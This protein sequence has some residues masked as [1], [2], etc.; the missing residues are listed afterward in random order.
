MFL[1]L[2]HQ[3]LEVF[4]ISRKLVKECY[5]ITREFPVTEKFALVSQIN[6][7]SISVYLN[8]AEGAS[9]R[10]LP[11][12]KRFFEIA[13]G[14]VIEIDAAFDLAKDVGYLQ[15]INTEILETCIL[16]CFKLLTN[17]IKN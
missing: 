17:L 5:Q 2:N 10:S 16:S 4:G 7:A 11:E 6:R 3:K 9:R 13:R 12:R 15:T 14:S 8:I 1:L